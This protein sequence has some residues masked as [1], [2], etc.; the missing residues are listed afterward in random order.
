MTITRT[1]L[2][3]RRHSCG[4]WDDVKT[5][6]MPGYNGPHMNILLTGALSWNPE[7]IISLAEGGHRLFGL[8]SRTMG[9]EQGPYAFAK[10]FI[11]DVDTEQ[12]VEL[13]SSGRIDL[14]YSLFQLYDR[15]LWS[16]QAARGLDNQWVQVRTLMN[17]RSA[18]SFRVPIVRHWGFDIHNIDLPVVR[19]FDAQI[20]CNRQKLQYW[21]A[22]RNQ[23]G[24]DL[25]LGFRNPGDKIPFLDS[26]LPSR[27]FMNDRFSPKLSAA[28]GEIHTVCI[29]RPVGINFA[30]AARH[31]IHVHIYG[32]NHDDVATLIARHLSPI[33]LAS[34]RRL[35]GHYVHIHP[36]IQPGNTTL[37]A[38]REAKDRWVAEFSRYDAGWSYI[39]RPLP[40]PK[41]EDQAAIPNRL[42]TYVLAGLPVISETLPGHHRYDVLA[43][44]DLAIDFRPR[45]YAKLAADLR[46]T[47]K[48][49]QM[50]ER[51]RA[52]RNEFSFEATLGPLLSC[53]ERISNRFPRR[54]PGSTAG[55]HTTS[56]P[57]PPGQPLQLF[58]RP[59]S[60]AGWRLPQARAGPW[61]SRMLLQGELLASRGRW[62][63]GKI[64]ARWFLSRWVREAPTHH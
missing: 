46:R 64:M 48:L 36:S 16:P 25:N 50:N 23:G 58:T 6:N 19:G 9:W 24:C 55:N 54:L 60:L 7:R 27:A 10:D 38:I 22:R 42:G 51:A 1:F 56:G 44:H 30:E 63:L 32:N 37:E 29:G 26:D 2:E 59:F 3:L 45:D 62:V 14:V 49:M 17:A 39:G 57:L 34:F 11:T 5:S 13:L 18:G 47:D 21:T 33:E 41:L 4:R 43:A 52:Y 15:R 31:K 61:T 40:W 53:F 35:I 8:W 28:S 20:F 12:S